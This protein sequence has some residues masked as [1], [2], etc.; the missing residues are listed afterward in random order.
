MTNVGSN[1]TISQH[2]TYGTCRKNEASIQILNAYKPV[3]VEI[4]VGCGSS[5]VVVGV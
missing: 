5:V 3:R 4:V 2:T 1:P